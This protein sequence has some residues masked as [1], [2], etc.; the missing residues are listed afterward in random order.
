M[1]MV[2]LAVGGRWKLPLALTSRPNC[3]GC[4]YLLLCIETEQNIYK[5]IYIYFYLS[6][7]LSLSLSLCICGLGP[8]DLKVPERVTSNEALGSAFRSR[9]SNLMVIELESVCVCVMEDG[10]NKGE[11]ELG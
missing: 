9:A 1:E 7:S 4:V 11:V 2:E 6:L 8:L 3:G 10:M 5:Y